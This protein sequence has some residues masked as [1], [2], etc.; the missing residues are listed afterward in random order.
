MKKITPIREPH[1]NVLE[2][3]EDPKHRLDLAAYK[4]VEL[5][6]KKDP[7]LEALFSNVKGPLADFLNEHLGPEPS[8]EA[9]P[10]RRRRVR[11]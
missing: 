7:V 9:K 11:L 8:R 10:R 5:L 3:V 2:T 4:A 6:S 1:V